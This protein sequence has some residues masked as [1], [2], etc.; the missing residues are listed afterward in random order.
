MAGT[1][2]QE[3]VGAKAR[4]R[5]QLRVCLLLVHCEDSA[6]F[7]C[8]MGS[9]GT[10]GPGQGLTEQDSSRGRGQGTSQGTAKKRRSLNWGRLSHRGSEGEG[11]E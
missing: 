5:A 2:G 7:L 3:V 10:Q 1:E 9:P 4:D 8:Q 6:S 11:P